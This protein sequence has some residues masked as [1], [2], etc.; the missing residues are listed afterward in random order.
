MFHK[1]SD[2]DKLRVFGS[3]YFPC[4]RS[5]R[6]NKLELKSAPCIFLGY[7]HKQDGYLSLVLHTHR[8]Y[9][10][11]D[12]VFLEDDFTLN[13][14]LWKDEGINEPEQVEVIP[15]SI[16]QTSSPIIPAQI[17]DSGDKD[18]IPDLNNSGNSPI[19][20]HPDLQSEQFIT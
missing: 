20:D 1:K 7:P 17:T 13:K 2:Y 12:V 9:S 16:I 14:L 10:S 15:V 5:Y 8:L 6:N 4:L 11:T 3:K 19:T 18:A